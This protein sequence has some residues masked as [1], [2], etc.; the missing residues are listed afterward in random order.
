MEPI[1]QKMQSNMWAACYYVEGAEQCSV[2]MA[3][4]SHG[5]HDVSA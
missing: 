5:C 1:M 3:A 2:K 4:I